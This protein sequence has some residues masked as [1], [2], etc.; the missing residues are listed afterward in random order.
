MK[1]AVSLILSLAMTMSAASAVTVS[2]Q[3]ATILDSGYSFT[4]IAR[5]SSGTYVAMAKDSNFTKI[6]LYY[7]NDG[8]NWQVS[9]NQ[10]ES[11]LPI[12]TNKES[13]QQLVYWAD[14]DMFLAHS[15]KGTYTSKD[16]VNWTL[17]GGVSKGE[18]FT[19][20]SSAMLSISGDR[21]VM[22]ANQKAMAPDKN[23]QGADVYTI[24]SI[25]SYYVKT[26]AAKPVDENG[27]I[28]VFVGGG[29]YA[30][31]LQLD[32]ATN[33]WSEVS[34]N[35]GSALPL[36][37]CDLIWADGAGQFLSI[38]PVNGLM[39]F[40]SSQ[41][42]ANISVN[43]STNVTGIGA[44]D[45]YIVAGM[46][47]GTMYYTENKEL[48]EDTVWTKIN[49]DSTTAA[50]SEPIK[51]IEFSSST[52][53]V[54]LGET[55]IYTA[56]LNGYSNINNYIKLEAPTVSAKNIF[57]GVR[58]IGGTYSPS[59]NR[60]VVYGDTSA[61]DDGGKYWG[62]IF[63][64]DN[65]RDWENVYTGYTFSLRST[66]GST[67]SYTE[68]RNGAVWWEAQKQFIVSASTKDHSGVTLVSADGRSWKA[69]LTSG[70]KD[71]EGN[72][73]S[74]LDTDF[75]LNTDMAIAGDM[76]YT[77][78]NGRQMRRYS[79]FDKTHMESVGLTQL[80]SAW[81]LNQIA[82]SDDA[83]PAVL[84][85]QNANGAV[86][87]NESEA[88]DELKK[89]T[90]INAFG[91][92]GYLMD[93]VFSK[94]LNKFVAVLNGGSKTS[95]VGKDGTV[96]Q[97][98]VVSQAFNAVDTNGDEFMFACRDGG[99]Y[100]AA[101][102]ADFA[103]GTV[104]LAKVPA[105]ASVEEENTMNV[106]NVFKARD[107][108][109]A[110]ASDNTDSDVLF[111]AKNTSG[112]YEYIKASENT[113]ISAPTPG[114]TIKI[115][116]QGMNTTD[117]DYGFDMIAAVWADGVLIQLQKDSLVLP[118]KTEGKLSAFMTLKDTLPE[119]AQLKIFKWDGVGTM[120]PIGEA[121]NPF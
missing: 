117:S 12:S 18:G 110:T 96:A 116:I 8:I 113:K 25:A 52:E 17:S 43:G 91:S 16:G 71:A 26:I 55:Q 97:G 5:S 21:L 109:I 11:A 105:A 107:S 31:D 19:W 111:I 114:Q 58:L 50:A 69:I 44:S 118:S 121:V 61:P 103:A 80:N 9:D 67:T 73:A 72:D 49:P 6:K 106:T 7:S 38:D 54:A 53:F 45:K 34:S 104:S 102:S 88:S 86:R 82:V 90:P 27:K 120:I 98:P 115:S 40:K 33:Q 70:N 37:P 83:D 89:W 56:D 66:N 77:T 81:Y 108:F 51:N 4:D 94:K 75:R 95:I 119:N 42:F 1:K 100:T 23:M 63:I 79:A 10:P 76:L 48:G 3:E 13:R 29:N 101:D 74:A 41:H 112:S 59:L 39:A 36:N 24:N 68:V 60:Y 47:D 99:V 87:N 65:G 30:Y 35:M 57:D 93:A 2:A 14:N 28:D 64:S 20:S 62:K 85:A 22:G 92:N 78:N 84:M 46:G 32:T 15:V